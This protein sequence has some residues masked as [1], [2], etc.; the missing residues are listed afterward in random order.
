M[1]FK[2]N[3]RFTQFR[4]LKKEE[5]ESKEMELKDMDLTEF[6]KCVCDYLKNGFSFKYLATII[7]KDEYKKMILNLKNSFILT[8]LE[9]KNPSDFDTAMKKLHSLISK[10]VSDLNE[11]NEG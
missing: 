7:Q 5:E 10:R 8:D 6:S 4:I 2:K 9:E 11:K 1:Q 3:F